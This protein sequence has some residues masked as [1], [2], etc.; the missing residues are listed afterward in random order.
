[1]KRYLLLMLSL[2]LVFFVVSCD[3]TGSPGTDTTAAGGEDMLV[4]VDGNVT[5][6]IVMRSDTKDVF[7]NPALDFMHRCEEITG[8]DLA[9]GTD[10]KDTPVVP[11][12]II[13][14]YTNREGTEYPELDRTGLDD[15]GYIIK[16]A[17]DRLLIIGNTEQGTQNG[18]DYFMEHYV[19]KDGISVPRDLEI[20]VNQEYMVKSLSISGHDI[21]EYVIVCDTGASA[22]VATAASELQR[23]IKA[24]CGTAPE[25]VISADG[26]PSITL[27]PTAFA[28][29]ETFSIKTNENG[30][31]IG[32][33]PV[34][35]VLYGV[36][37]FLE[38]YIGWRFLAADTEV[39]MAEETVTI[40]N[41]DYTHSPYFEYRDTYWVNHFDSAF[42]AK[43]TVN[44][45]NSRASDPK[46]GGLV[47]YTGQFVHT[48]EPLLGVPMTEQPC[49]SEE[50]TYEDTLAAV[51]KILEENPDARIISV[52]QNDNYNSCQCAN[53]LATDAEEGSPAGTLLRFV[54]RIA[55]AVEKDYPKLAIHTLAYQYT[56]EAPK[57]TVPRD[58]VIVQLCTIECC[59]NHA[60]DDETCEK[61]RAL[62]EDMIAWSKICNRIYVWDY[63]TNFRFYAA[64]FPNFD[65]IAANIRFFHEHNVKGLFE[66][67]NYQSGGNAELGDLRAYLL[68][69]LMYD[70]YMEKEE[71]ERHINEFLQGYYG[72]GWEN[73]RKYYD[74]IQETSNAQGDFGIY[75]APEEMYRFTDFRDRHEEISSWFD[76][77]EAA[78]ATDLQL[79]HVKH[80]RLSFTYLKWYFLYD[81]Y[82]YASENQEQIELAKAEV[83]ALFDAMTEFNVR[84]GEPFMAMG[85]YAPGAVDKTASPKEWYVARTS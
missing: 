10:W 77:A 51:L 11:H 13:I 52:S 8:C 4:I 58:N 45:S 47:G 75:N 81:K 12:E 42:S 24:A 32:G 84:L 1:M 66:Q 44:S 33:T 82:V 14:G 27:D 21:G 78:A 26:K 55:E 2:L 64:P 5:D 35:G 22:S 23:Y 7:K 40:D 62:K 30:V 71:Y 48:F 56:R 15:E 36:Y 74:F 70:P 73:I 9:I 80:T 25:I 65:V 50:K 67:G 34:R 3:S 29:D 17:D 41:I 54:N 57:I 16:V 83:S 28:D 38:E 20:H 6:Y 49:L 63:T 61:N 60:L 53:C 59:F 85:E 79:A 43:R 37:R 46:L 18:V 76:A 31:V 39:L 69:K 19:T 72:D 68:S